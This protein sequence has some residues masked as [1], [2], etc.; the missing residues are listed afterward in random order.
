VQDDVHIA[1]PRDEPDGERVALEVA[2]LEA[3]VDLHPWPFF[4]HS[5][6]GPETVEGI[7]QTLEVLPPRFGHDIDVKSSEAGALEAASE[8]PEHT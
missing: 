6:P 4:S 7:R 2:G 8:A 3:A 5:P 1:D